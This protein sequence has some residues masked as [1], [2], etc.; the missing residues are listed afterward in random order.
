MMIAFEAWPGRMLLLTSEDDAL[1]YPRLGL[2]QERYPQAETFVFEAGGHHTYLF[3]PEAY[4]EVLQSFLA[5]ELRGTL[6]N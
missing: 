5:G 6:A 2:L 3:F 4:T 1:S